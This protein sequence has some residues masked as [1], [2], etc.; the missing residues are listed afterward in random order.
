MA[1]RLRVSFND[2][3]DGTGLLTLNL[4]SDGFS[5]NGE[6][7]V[8]VAEIRSFAN[9]VATNAATSQGAASLFG[10]YYKS[11]KLTTTLVRL[12]VTAIDG[13]GHFRVRV[14]LAAYIEESEL[15]FN[16]PRVVGVIHSDSAELDIFAAELHSLVDKHIEVAT[17]G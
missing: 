1:K 5:G 4:D 14:E 8:P 6:A 11:G 16:R 3:L 10:G 2:D 12:D 7:C 17:L 13:R 9:V 15:D